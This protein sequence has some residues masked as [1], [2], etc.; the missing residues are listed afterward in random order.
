MAERMAERK[1]HAPFG[2]NEGAEPS[3]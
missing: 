1:R 2:Q 3:L